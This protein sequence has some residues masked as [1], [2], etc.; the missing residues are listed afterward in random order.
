M[1]KG[2]LLPVKYLDPAIP[3]MAPIAKADVTKSIQNVWVGFWGFAV[4]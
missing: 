4:L 2:N 3:A 1:L